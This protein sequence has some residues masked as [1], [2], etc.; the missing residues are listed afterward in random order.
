MN[1]VA[2]DTSS[3]LRSNQYRGAEI[4]NSKGSQ[5]LFSFS[6]FDNLGFLGSFQ[7]SSDFSG[8][9]GTQVMAGLEGW[10]NNSGGL[11]GT[12]ITSGTSSTAATLGLLAGFSGSF[13][14][15]E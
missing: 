8:L 2:V 4:K 7:L 11:S 6:V 3:F 9:S 14:C 12:E 10:S 1:F 15:G 5:E 13:C